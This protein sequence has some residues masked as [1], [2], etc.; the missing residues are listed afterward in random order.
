M[1][2]AQEGGSRKQFQTVRIQSAEAHTSA[3][4]SIVIGAD[5]LQHEM[6]ADV[7]HGSITSFSACSLNV[8]CSPQ[9]DEKSGHA[10]CPKCANSCQVTN[11][12]F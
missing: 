8:A 11:A 5:A 2:F 3:Q 4:T 10:G 1:P 7:S 12:T 9:S 6:L